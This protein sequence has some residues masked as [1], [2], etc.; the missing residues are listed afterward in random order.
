MLKNSIAY[1]TDLRNFFIN[2]K[3]IF[4]NDILQI[5]T[6]DFEDVLKEFPPGPLD[7]YRK[8]ATFKWQDMRI[9]V[10]GEDGLLLKVLF[11]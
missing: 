11:V 10:E 8:Q 7:F 6:E 5:N 9:L 4:S 2:P 1:E 3:K